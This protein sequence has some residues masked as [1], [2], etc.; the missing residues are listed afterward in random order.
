MVKGSVREGACV[1]TGVWGGRG[2]EGLG[3]QLMLICIDGHCDTLAPP[4]PPPSCLQ[5]S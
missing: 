4:P 2:G 1:C 3:E 5:P